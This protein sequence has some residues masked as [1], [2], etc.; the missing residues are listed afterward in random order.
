[1]PSIFDAK[2]PL[3][4]IFTAFQLEVAN[5][6]GYMFNDVVKDSTSKTRL[7][8]GYATA[9]LGAYLYNTLYSSLVG[10]DAAF[11]PVSIIQELLGDL[12]D[13][14]EE[15]EDVLLNFGENVLEEV[16]FI[17]GF[18]G[19]G[20]VPIQSALPYGTDSTPFERMLNDVTEG[21]WV[22]FGKELLNPL[23]YLVMPVGGGQFKKSAEGLSMFLLPMFSDDHPV[24]GS[25]TDSGKL[26]FPVEDTIGNKVQAALFGQYASENARDYFDNERSPLDG[27][28]IQEYIDVEVPIGE[29]WKYREGL[30]GLKTMAEK[31][32]YINSLDLEPWQKNLLINNIADRKED[33][34]M[35]S[36][37][38]YSSF[39]EF[40]YATKNPEK[41]KFLTSNGVTYEDYENGT[42][43][44]KDAWSWASKNPEKFTLAKA[45]CDDLVMYKRF[46]GELDDIRADKDA[47]GDTISGSAKTKKVKYI[48]G[49]N[50]DYGQK[51]ILFKS[52]YKSDDTYNYDIIEYLD[53]RDDIS[54]DQMVTIL[55]ELGFDVSSDG[56]VSW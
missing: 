23:Y 35:T 2:N 8:K 50:L 41:Y 20:R 25:Y 12:W 16:P 30:K 48:D 46:T 15:P 56:T 26:R 19:G 29:Y 18:L 14:E 4:K 5:Y 27:K 49:L 3:T 38:E 51:I 6:Y 31:A 40:D 1:M 53:N 21:N 34:D 32:D 33:I 54:Y 17:G 22:N 47:Y 36:Y 44:F 24:S 9:F 37:G 43:E 28:Q 11:D 39:A 45:V 13:D 7:V 42:D 55:K 52:Q 10:R